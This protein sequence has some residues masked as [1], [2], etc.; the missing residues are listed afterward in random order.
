LVLAG[1]NTYTGSTTLLRGTVRVAAPETPNV[2][3]PLG[4]HPTNAVGTILLKGGTLQY[5][6]SNQFDYSG[7]FS[8]A[9]N[10][11]YT[12]DTTNQSVTWNAPLASLGGVLTKSGLG[13]LTLASTNNSFSGGTTVNLGKLRALANGTLGSGDVVVADGAILELNAAAALSTNANLSLMGG[14]PAVQLNFTGTQAVHSLSFDGGVT[15]AAPGIWG[16][17]GS[18]ATYTNSRFTGSGRLL[19]AS[20]DE[21][22]PIYATW[23]MV[24]IKSTESWWN[25]NE[26]LGATDFL[27]SFGSINWDDD[28]Y[29]SS[30]L[31]SMKAAGINA[32]VCDLTNGWGWLNNLV[33]SI[34]RLAL[35]KRMKVCVAVGNIPSPKI[36]TFESRCGDIWN[37]FAGPSAP[38]ASTYLQK[39]GKPVIVCYVVKSE[40]D[41]YVASIGTNRQ[42]FTLVWGAGDTG[43]AAT[44]DVWG[45]Q[46][47]PANGTAPSTNAVFVTPS[48]KYAPSSV[49]VDLWRKSQ[50]WLDYNFKVAKE[51]QPAF[52]IVGSF[53][54]MH[55][56]NGWLP[57]DTTGSIPGRQMR[58]M[59]GAIST[60][61]Y[62]NRVREWILG[63]PS[64]VPG[65]ALVDG[66]YL[67]TNRSSALS[68]YMPNSVGTNQ[69]Y[70]GMK[71]LQSTPAANLNNYFSF[72]MSAYK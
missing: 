2:S 11:Y 67:V 15:L 33:Q 54:D 61:S 14:S 68:L 3:G 29:V 71:L 37:L 18:G 41:S 12:V 9:S 65:G 70:V 26:Y 7:R 4:K 46:L 35:G 64:A 38:Y 23:C 13:T 34:Q 25:P 69:A 19:V 58:D 72:Y 22:L 27:G 49:S 55:E 21:D 66:C 30:S 28:T 40:Y 57:A 63:T 24:W 8:T 44:T 62:Y 20:A 39:D 1:T 5:S 59:T 32:I 16:A 10:Q 52:T 45:W 51:S 50:A 42:R 53:D 47:N 48:I 6:S 43:S 56:R 17:A 36:D 60:N 31:V